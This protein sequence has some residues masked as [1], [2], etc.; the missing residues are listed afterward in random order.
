MLTP[1]IIFP[2]LGAVPWNGNILPNFKSRK[3]FPTNGPKLLA[4]SEIRLATIFVS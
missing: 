3:R 2:E 1:L 4:K